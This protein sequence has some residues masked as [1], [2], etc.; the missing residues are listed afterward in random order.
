MSTDLR[1]TLEKII[2]YGGKKYGGDITDKLKNCQL[3]APPQHM[4]EVLQKHA[5]KVNLKRTQ[6]NSLLG[7]HHNI[8][9]NLQ[10]DMAANPNSA[11]TLELVEINNLIAQL[12]QHDLTEDIPIKLNTEVKVKCDARVKSHNKKLEDLKLHW[13]KVYMLIMG[14][15]VN[16]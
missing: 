3:T 13:R 8:A 14:Q 6:Q 15:L 1:M 4:T 9:A 7:A 11:Q 5:A 10:A 2:Q 16:N 12:L